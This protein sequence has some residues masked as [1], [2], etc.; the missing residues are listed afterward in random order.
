MNYTSNFFEIIKPDDWHI[1]LREG[2]MLKAVIN[3]STRINVRC[4]V[5]PNLNIPITTSYLA[6]KYRNE[7][8]NYGDLKSFKPLIPCYLTENLDLKDFKFSLKNDIFIGAKLYPLNATT[9]SNF[10]IKKI[11]TIFP[12]LEILEKLNKPLLIH[13]EKIE[14]N[15]NIFDRE[16]YFIDDELTKII[17]FFPFLKIV[18]EHVSS[19]Y[20]ADFIEQND[21]LAGTITPQHMLLTKKDVFQDNLNVYNYCMPI[22]KEEYDLIALRKY[23]CSGNKKFFL[24]TDSAPHNFLEK[25]NTLDVK[26]GIF[27]APCSIELYTDIFDQENSLEKL[28]N[29]TSIN[30]PSFYNMPLNNDKIKLIKKEWI[31]EEFTIYN[32]IKIRNFFAGK[33]INWKIQY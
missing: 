21:N 8:G 32:D 7:I 1:H 31:V 24:G 4:V 19:K 3:S 33:K 14:D 11:E 6:K 2:E 25:E 16:K 30:G 10:G 29:F 9:N 12:A 5:M 23:A 22:V 28:E 20:G 15:I 27:S 26:P 17:K 18:L 13:G